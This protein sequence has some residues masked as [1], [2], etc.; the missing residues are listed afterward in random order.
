MLSLTSFL[1]SRKLKTETKQSTTFGQNQFKICP[2]TNEFTFR[3]LNN[4]IRCV[5]I[6]H[7]RLI[8][9]KSLIGNHCFLA[10]VASTLQFSLFSTVGAVPRRTDF[11]RRIPSSLTALTVDFH[12]RSYCLIFVIPINIVISRMIRIISKIVI[13]QYSVTN[14]SVQK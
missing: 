14:T 2:M 13:L 9:L 11:F 1:T 3:A 7:I 12:R 6:H 10:L 4:Q 8:L 5:Q